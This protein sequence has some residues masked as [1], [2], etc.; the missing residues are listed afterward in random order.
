MTIFENL[1][2]I[3]HQFFNLADEINSM[4]ESED[5]DSVI[6]KLEYKDKLIKKLQSTKKTVNFTEDELRN[7]S[8]IEEKLK[9]KEDYN[10]NFLDK[11]RTA[12][13][14][15]LDDTKSKLKMNTAYAIKTENNSGMYVDLSE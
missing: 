13:G 5:Y 7:L 12:V 6:L 11:L 14:V 3:Y 2:L 1:E 4:I 8:L 9:E 15:E 10:I